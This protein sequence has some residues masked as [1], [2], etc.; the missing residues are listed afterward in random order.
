MDGIRISHWREFVKFARGMG[1][2]MQL[3]FKANFLVP[4]SFHAFQQHS[5][6]AISEAVH[7]HVRRGAGHG[8]RREGLRVHPPSFVIPGYFHGLPL[9]K[10]PVASA[11]L[12]LFAHREG[13]NANLSIFAFF[14]FPCL[15]FLYLFH[16]PRIL[17]I[18]VAFP[19]CGLVCLL[20]ED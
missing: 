7:R 3:V 6:A 9:R 4:L 19:V 10:E 17:E 13:L 2:M 18:S 15:H 5:G 14:A 1:V 8:R 12:R 11:S 16:F 20:I